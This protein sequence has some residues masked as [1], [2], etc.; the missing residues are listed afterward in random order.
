MTLR[1]LFS[2]ASIYVA[3]S[4]NVALWEE[5]WLDAEIKYVFGAIYLYFIGFLIALKVIEKLSAVI[6]REIALFGFGYNTKGQIL[7]AIL[8][9]LPVLIF[10]GGG[11]LALIW[12]LFEAL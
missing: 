3:K 11:V 1:D 8:V 6:K 7:V 5:N 10:F 2:D 9:A 12:E 4:L